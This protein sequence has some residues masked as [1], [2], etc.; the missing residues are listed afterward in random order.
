[1][2]RISVFNEPYSVT[3]KAEGKII[4]DWVSELRN[5]WL[6]M[7]SE[8]GKR[9]KVIDLFNVSFVDELGRQ[10]LKD[11]H[12]AGAQLVGSG[13]MISGLIEEIQSPAPKYRPRTLKKVLLSLLFLLLVGLAKAAFGQAPP[14]REVLKLQD[15]IRMARN[16]NLQIKIQ[17]LELS[18][19]NDSVAIAKTKR[20]ASFST[21]LYG[22]GLLAP[23]SFTF[24]RGALGTFPATGPI[25]DKKTEIT[26][27]RNFNF[28]VNTQ[29]RQPISQIYR[30]NLGVR[31]QEAGKK[32]ASEQ[33]RQLDQQV[34]HDVRE[35]YLAIVQTRSALVAN[36]SRLSSL[37]ELSRVLQARLQLQTVLPADMMEAKAALAR[38]EQ[39]ELTYNDDLATRKEQ[40]NVLLG[41]DPA[42][43]FEVEAVPA[44]EWQDQD[45][46][47]LQARAVALRPEVRAYDQREKAADY[48]RRIK[49][50]ERLPDVG[51]FVNYISPFNV[52]VVPRYTAAAGIQV[53]W[54]PFDWGRRGHEL[55][56]K[57]KIVEQT[58]LAGQQQR[59]A[60][61]IEVAHAFRSLQEAR[62][63][64][65]VTQLNAEA[66]QE[67]LRV[68][69]NQFEE[70][71]AL[72]KDV[73]DAQNKVA[74]AQ[75]KQQE[76]LLAYWKAKAD[77][78]KA[79]GED[80]ES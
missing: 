37:R 13:P 31:A 16:N 29:V 80:Y 54:E 77:F 7:L 39:D 57:E 24:D 40:L 75:H 52:D 61:R 71:A 20:L 51:A 10:L 25:P 36:R 46:P 44:M 27:P 59:D 55:A 79:M 2:L 19:A 18:K 15:A 48:D 14:A 62:M 35:A 73:L 49:K 42:T 78:V 41:R 74:D 6:A 9:K 67:R 45:L 69:T 32:I 63:L 28:F 22:S 68:V 43:E 30:I 8:A 12:A 50:A 66:A 56:Q 5:A 65:E 72:A 70:R 76:A 38:A 60:V 53:T 26:A 47:S 4:Q 58:R 64:A 17:Q 21:D 3:L 1:M 11:M 34:V 33:A 23:I